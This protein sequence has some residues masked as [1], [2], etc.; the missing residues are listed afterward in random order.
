MKRLMALIMLVGCALYSTP[1]SAATTASHP[2]AQFGYTA[3][4]FA[5]THAATGGYWYDRSRAYMWGTPPAKPY[6]ASTGCRHYTSYAKFAS[7][8][9]NHEISTAKYPCVLL[10]LEG[11]KGWPAPAAEMANPRK[12]MPLFNKLARLHGFLPIEVPAAD[13]HRTD[14]T[15]GGSSN[16]AYYLNCKL[17]RYAAE[18][19]ADV[20]VQDQSKQAE[21]SAYRDWYLTAKSQAH[22]VYAS[23][24]VFSTCS[25]ARGPAS[26]CISDLLSIG[27]SAAMGLEIMQD[28]NADA[29]SAHGWLATVLDTLRTDGW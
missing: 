29:R 21:Q 4:E 25:Q 19:G 22:S 11:G 3:S 7:D 5:R 24:V 15:C 12:Y 28:T 6:A 20:L 16:M 27:K 23:S 9:A 1:A 10:D 17:A 13:L 18:G 26:G 8:V 2:I 14:T